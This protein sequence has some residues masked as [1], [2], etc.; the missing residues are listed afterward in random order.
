MNHHIEIPE[1]SRLFGLEPL[2]L[3]T[4]EAEGLISYL[5]RLAGAH[6]ISPKCLLSAELFRLMRG[7][8]SVHHAEFYTDYAKTLHSTGKFAETFVK[9]VEQLTCRTDIPLMTALPW[10]EIIPAIGTGFMTQHPKWCHACWAEDRGN[11][12]TPYS[13]LS[14]GFALYQVCARHQIP[15]IDACPWCGKHQPFFADHA[16]ISRCNTCYGWLATHATEEEAVSDS[17]QVWISHAIE[18]MVKHGSIA[19]S[20]VTGELFRGR[21]TELVNTLANGQKTRLS[22]M[23]GLTRST[24]AAWITKQQKPL[25]PQF[26]YMCHQLDILPS[27]LLFSERGQGISIGNQVHAVRLH[28]IAPK[29]G[30]QEPPKADVYLQLKDI[31]N[32][33]SD[34][35]SLVEITTNLAL[36]RKY[37][38]YW[39]PDECKLISL[40]HKQHKY[41]QAIERRREQLLLIRNVTWRLYVNGLYPSNRQ[42]AKM[43]APLKMSLLKPHLR[44]THRRALK[45]LYECSSEMF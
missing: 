31:C 43:I 2:G 3:G 7:V 44:A 28:H 8:N 25:F 18:D 17:K 10:S 30:L 37:L 21:L 27:E 33:A 34:C 14:W 41:Q 12:R 13:R 36:T 22:E 1:R 39:F 29:I 11:R 6:C 20:D 23:L 38:I 19:L 16:V 32:D 24:M 45:Q 4:E 26:L 9:I 15:L 42:V 40:K 5:I 35:R